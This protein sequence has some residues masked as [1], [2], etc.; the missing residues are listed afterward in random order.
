MTVWTSHT[1][2]GLR[3][4]PRERPSLPQSVLWDH[5][6]IWLPQEPRGHSYHTHFTDVETE[7]HKTLPTVTKL[8]GGRA[9]T[10][11]RV[12]CTPRL[13]CLY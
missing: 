2:P 4:G 11:N 10:G 9:G 3:G 8:V 1:L 5:S 7:V 6:L 12:H 13:C